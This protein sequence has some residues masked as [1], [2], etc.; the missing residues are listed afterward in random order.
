[1]PTRTPA[2]EVDVDTDLARALLRDQH[3]DL[4]RLPLTLVEAGW[5]NTMVR[6]GDEWVMRLPRRALAAGLT[7]HEQRWLPDLAPRLPLPVP[8]PV[9]TGRPGHGYP[10]NWSVLPWLP[11]EPADLAPLDPAAATVLSGFLRSLHQ[12]APAQAPRNPFRGVPLEHRS[13]LVG[14]RL[15][16]LHGRHPAVDE[17]I[18]ALWQAALTAAPAERTG[19]IHGD[20]HARNVLVVDGAISA[21]IDWGD[22]C[23]GD[24]ATDLASVWML[25][26]DPGARQTARDDYPADPATWRRARGW[27]VSFGAVLLETGLADNPRNAALGERILRRL[28]RD[29]EARPCPTRRWP[30]R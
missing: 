25:L 15:R 13:S 14:E 4:A 7:A 17:R 24:P 20:L 16:R 12:P 28:A 19:W 2:A 23:A 30:G 1:M 29:G 9:R 21:V 26:E 27:A 6:I 8:A 3:P 5:D 11:G 22:V 18:L 10:W